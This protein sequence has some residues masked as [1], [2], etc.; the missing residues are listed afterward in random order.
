ML[1]L[2][3]RLTPEWDLTLDH[4][5]FGGFCVRARNDGKSGRMPIR[6]AR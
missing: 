1:D 6:T 3:Y 4:Q 2:T 5:A